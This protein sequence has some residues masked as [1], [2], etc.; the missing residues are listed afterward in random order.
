MFKLSQEP[1][2]YQ[3]TVHFHNYENAYSKDSFVAR[4]NYVQKHLASDFVQ[5][6]Q[7]AMYNFIQTYGSDKIREFIKTFSLEVAA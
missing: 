1:I 3:L 7:A 2:D 6:E 4:F 5:K